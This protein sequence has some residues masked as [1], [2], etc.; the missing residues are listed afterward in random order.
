MPLASDAATYDALL[1]LRYAILL[2]YHAVSLMLIRPRARLSI[3]LLLRY[4]ASAA[5]IEHT[6]RERTAGYVMRAL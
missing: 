3:L 1:L 2:R 5:A 4:A 6:L